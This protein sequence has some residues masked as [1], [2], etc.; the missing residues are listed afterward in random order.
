MSHFDVRWFDRGRPPQ[1][2]SNPDF[3]HGINI[4][5][6]QRPACRVELPYMTQKHVGYWLV[7]CSKCES[8]A[9][10]T[11]ASRPDDPKSVMLPCKKNE[12]GGDGDGV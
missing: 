6:G 1:V 11:M 8:S 5:S 2:A 12:Q 9:L 4:D 7:V 3:P 10:I